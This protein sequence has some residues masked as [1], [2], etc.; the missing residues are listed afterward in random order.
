MEHRQLP[1]DARAQE[2]DRE[3]I[4]D[5]AQ[6]LDVR[7]VGVARRGRAPRRRLAAV[8]GP[9]RT[10]ISKETGLLKE[11]PAGGP[12]VVWTATGL[13]AG[14]GSMAVAGTRV[15]VQGMRGTTSTVIALHRADGK[16]VWAKALGQPEDNDRGP[17]PRGTPTVDGDRLYVL[18]ENGDL[19]CLK[20]DGAIVWQRNILKEFGGSQLRWLISESP[21]VDGSNLVVTPGDRAP[22]WSS[23]TRS[24]GR[25]SGTTRSERPGRLLLDHGRRHRGRPY[26]HDV[27]RGRGRRY[28]RAD[29]KVMFSY[30][31][32]A[33]RIANVASPIFSNNKV[34]FSRPTERAAGCWT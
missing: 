28:P 3:G 26:L 5:H 18:T 22:A 9:D 21:L 7:R 32:A 19:A 34:F 20:T 33:N 23:W 1:A 31:K 15:F 11:W 24:P 10:R 8:A 14:F 13:G 27:Y 17:G 30:T 6:N 4:R 16:E 29:G 2:V 12:K 25:P